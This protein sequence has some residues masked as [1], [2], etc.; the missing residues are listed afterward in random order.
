MRR[1]CE[2]P[3][4][5]IGRGQ[6]AGNGPFEPLR[7]RI[8]LERNRLGKVGVG[9]PYFVLQPGAQ[10][11]PDLVRFLQGMDVFQ[12]TADFPGRNRRMGC[13]IEGMAVGLMLSR[14]L[15]SGIEHWHQCKSRLALL[16]AA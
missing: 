1:R 8:A 14:S 9:S 4:P 16:N 3:D 13:L 7:S 10:K 15:G 6:Y 12:V 2:G 5:G 11:F